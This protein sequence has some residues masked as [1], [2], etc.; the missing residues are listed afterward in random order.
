[1][2]FW[3]SLTEVAGALGLYRIA[4]AEEELEPLA[5]FASTADPLAREISWSIL[6]KIKPFSA[7]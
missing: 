4:R 1:M 6:R 3:E 7:R 2:S 5:L